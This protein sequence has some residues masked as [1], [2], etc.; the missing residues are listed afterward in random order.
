MVVA[1]VPS[2]AFHSH[3]ITPKKLNIFNHHLTHFDNNYY[4]LPKVTGSAYVD[5]FISIAEVA[6]VE[7]FT[8]PSRFQTYYCAVAMESR[9]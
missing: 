9:L 7:G 8:V 6:L 3:L 2:A 4:D 5:C 1:S